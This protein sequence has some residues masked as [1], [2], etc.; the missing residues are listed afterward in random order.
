M[1]FCKDWSKVVKDL[2][3]D[4]IKG[5]TEEEV[6]RRKEKYGFNKLKEAK[7]K[8]TLQLFLAQLND[9]LIYILLV[10]AII[11]GFMEEM[12]DTVIIMAVVVLNAVI[13]VSQEMK[14]EKSMEALKNLTTPKAY[15]I[16]NG[17][18][19]EIDSENIVPGD[20]VVL[21][22]GRFIPCD[23]RLIET[24]NMRVEE[25]A[26]TGESVPVN[27]DA[28]LVIDD[29]KIP[30]GDRKNM[31]FSSTLVTSGRGKGVVIATGM[32]T[33]IGKIADMLS[34]EDEKTPLQIKLAD[35]GKLLG[36]I[37]L[38]IC[39]VMFFISIVQKR[40]VFEMLLTAVSLA[41]AA[42]PEGLPAIVSIVLAI[43]VQRMVK[44]NAIV[45]KLPSVETLG[46]CTV[47]CSDK[48]GTLTQNRMTVMKYYVDRETIDIENMNMDDKIHKTLIEGFMLCSDATSDGEKS[49]GDPTEVALIDAGIK[50]SVSPEKLNADNPRV[51]EAPFD[52]GRKMMSTIN[53]YQGEY[54]VFTKGAT[55]VLLDRMTNAIEDGKVVEMTEDIRNEISE[56]VEEFSD[57][58]LRVLTLAFKKVD[59]YE[60]IEQD[61][62]EKDL[63]FIGLVAMIDPPRLEVKDSIETCKKAGITTVMITG[64]HQKTAFAIA[65]DLGIAL[66]YD[67]TMSGV[68]I[69]SISDEELIEKV[70][71]KRVFSR[72]SPEHKVRIVKAFKALGNIVSMTG[73][74][75]NDAPSLKV[76]DI[77]VAMGITG[78]DVAKGASDVIL[79]DDNFK[80]IVTAV[81]EGR[82]IYANI[83]K[84]VLFL[85]S[86]NIGEILSVFVSVVLGWPLPLQSVH[87][88]WVNLI[89]D[90]F[91]AISLGMDPGDKEVMKDKPRNPDESLF[92]NRILFLVLN[93]VFIGFIT[94]LAFLIGAMMYSNITSLPELL[95]HMTDLDLPV[96]EKAEMHARTM[97]FATLA[98]SQ[99]FHA[100]N[101]R[102]EKKSIFNIGLTTNKY[103]IYS[104]FGGFVIQLFVFYIPFLSHAFKV[105]P[106]KIVD[107]AIVIGLGLLTIVLNEIFK[108]FL[109]KSE[110]N[111]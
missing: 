105:T 52:S 18:T 5:L 79:T 26:L 95:T 93:G 106:L 8:S 50:H 15:V 96:N 6:T 14:A 99:L 9:P 111:I 40:D 73:D 80:T 44:K 13:G 72:V 108:I 100:F 19:I 27:K 110:N 32:D 83:K 66:D 71:E 58:A 55:D 37:A 29:E 56:K 97:A 38:A 107:W 78:T 43:G 7:K 88:L 11:S 46:A 70:K 3:T 31:A 74:G 64:D 2:E 33:E 85:L 62:M 51:N 98:I 41:V 63:I 17:E 21:D 61:D 87:L 67:K 109:R 82:N 49:T 23:M 104:L 59:S 84:S 4:P 39:I 20:I 30:L 65:K 34:E 54:I 25:S 92:H 10:A 36:I 22:A 94:L 101:L 77:G 68:E 1:Y 57:D 103:L 53:N 76:A 45:R 90:T 28:N 86:C 42:I 48:T 24:V 89:T 69:D 91:P 16:R 81:E 102:H 47:I 12:S 35:I 75:V 60:N